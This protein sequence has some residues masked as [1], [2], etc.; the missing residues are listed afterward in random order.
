[1]AKGQVHPDRNGDYHVEPLQSDGRK[2]SKEPKIQI[3]IVTSVAQSVEL[4]K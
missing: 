1:M 3:P 4:A 2:K